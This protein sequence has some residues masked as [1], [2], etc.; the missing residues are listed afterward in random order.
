[1]RFLNR[2]STAGGGGLTIGGPVNL[3][4]ATPFEIT[5]SG[6]FRKDLDVMTGVTKHDGSY[7]VAC[8]Y[9]DKYI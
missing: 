5:R 7:F 2:I 8:M 1:M 4:P 6:N 3:F 9:S